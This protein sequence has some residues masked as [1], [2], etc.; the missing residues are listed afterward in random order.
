MIEEKEKIIK[1]IEF[2]VVKFANRTYLNDKIIK[3]LINNKNN[4]KLKKII[5]NLK[6]YDKNKNLIDISK[7]TACN[8][9]PNSESIFEE[10]L[11]DIQDFAFYDVKLYDISCDSEHGSHYEKAIQKIDSIKNKKD[12]SFFKIDLTKY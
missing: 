10:S 7:I 12:K 9:Q 8:I 2:E 5:F 6:L 4:I 3:I 1:N 11:F